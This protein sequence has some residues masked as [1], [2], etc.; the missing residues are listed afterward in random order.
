MDEPLTIHP[1]GGEGACTYTVIRDALE[2]SYHQI[3]YAGD[4][5]P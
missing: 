3:A 2:Q 4:T 1:F 5:Y